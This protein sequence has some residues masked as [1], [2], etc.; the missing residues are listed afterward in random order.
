LRPANGNNGHRPPAR[1]WERAPRLTCAAIGI[2]ALIVLLVLFLV[3]LAHPTI[4]LAI[5][6]AMVAFFG[7][8]LL[9]WKD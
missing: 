3:G 7:V 5:G 8:A 4:V 1:F 2:C 9:I 6:A